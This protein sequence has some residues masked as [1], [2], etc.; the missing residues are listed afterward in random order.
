MHKGH[1]W[2]QRERNLDREGIVKTNKSM[3][4]GLAYTDC[5]GNRWYTVGRAVQHDFGWLFEPQYMT[6]DRPF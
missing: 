6:L 2:H 5:F 1:F 3:I 4:Y